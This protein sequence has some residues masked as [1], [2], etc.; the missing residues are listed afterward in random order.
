MP[1]N[2][3]ST[4]SLQTILALSLLVIVTV[5]GVVSVFNDDSANN[6]APFITEEA[7]NSSLFGTDFLS[8][9]ASVSQ[10]D[11]KSEV[12]NDPMFTRLVDLRSPL[13]DEPVG[14]SNPFVSN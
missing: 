3:F 8:I 10:I 11:I 5:V 4:I 12:L 14:K 2:K 9:I 13:T 6:D 1:I 7:D